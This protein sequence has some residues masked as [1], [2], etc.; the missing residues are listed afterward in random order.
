MNESELPPTFQEMLAVLRR[1]RDEHARVDAVESNFAYVF[2][3]AL[4][5]PVKENEPEDHLGGWLRI[6]VSFPDNGP[7][8][9]VTIVPLPGKNGGINGDNHNPGHGNASPVRGRGGDHYYSW[10]WAESPPVRSPADI[11]GVVRWFE[12]RIRLGMT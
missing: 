5:K 3:H 6:P 4:R 8:G 9:L 10:T 11:L 12:R 7:W 2:V 1:E